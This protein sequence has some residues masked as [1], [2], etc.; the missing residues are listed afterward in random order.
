MLN[1]N[2][3]INYYILAEEQRELWEKKEREKK[4]ITEQVEDEQIQ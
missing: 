3:A 1:I 2:F 4:W